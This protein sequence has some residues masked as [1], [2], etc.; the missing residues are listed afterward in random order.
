MSGVNDIVELLDELRPLLE[1]SD[2]FNA[3]LEEME[4]DTSN[5]WQWIKEQIDANPLYNPVY[6]PIGIDILNKT[7]DAKRRLFKDAEHFMSPTH[8]IVFDMYLPDDSK[9]RIYDLLDDI[10]NLTRD[11]PGGGGGASGIGGIA[12]TIDDNSITGKLK[13]GGLSEMTVPVLWYHYVA[14]YFNDERNEELNSWEANTHYAAAVLAPGLSG[15][16]LQGHDKEGNNF[17]WFWPI[18]WD[19]FSAFGSAGWNEPYTTDPFR[20]NATSSTVEQARARF[21]YVN[22]SEWIPKPPEMQAP[23]GFEEEF[24]EGGPSLRLTGHCRFDWNIHVDKVNFWM[25]PIIVSSRYDF[26]GAVCTASE[27]RYDTSSGPGDKKTSPAPTTPL[28]TIIL[29]GFFG[30]TSGLILRVEEEEE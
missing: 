21:S 9:N 16:P 5:G 4:R 12:G 20:G 10:L 28:T 26:V 3:R 22:R 17:D 13:Y 29:A 6:D 15:M 23:E 25:G 2:D 30:L 24:L 1:M 14:D 11:L 7:R 8:R 18:D 27:K 19:I